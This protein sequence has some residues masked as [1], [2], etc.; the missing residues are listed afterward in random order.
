MAPPW[1]GALDHASGQRTPQRVEPLPGTAIKDS[2]THTDDQAT[3]KFRVHH[4]R[5]AYIAAQRRRKL[6]GNALCVV[7]R[8]LDG[9]RHFYANHTLRR[10]DKLAVLLV[11]L[12]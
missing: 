6:S 1:G 2:V 7:I 4:G 12:R 9:G 3:K 5:D 11:D 8:Q 10:V